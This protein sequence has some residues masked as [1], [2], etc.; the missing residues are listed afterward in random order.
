MVYVILPNLQVVFFF[1]CPI[2]ESFK[3]LFIYRF[4][5]DNI[6]VYR[7]TIIANILD[8]VVDYMKLKIVKS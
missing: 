5:M 2:I 6:V 4:T 1:I 8:K 3:K 7:T